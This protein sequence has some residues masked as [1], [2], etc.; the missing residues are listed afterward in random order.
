MDAIIIAFNDNSLERSYYLERET[1]R[2]FNLREDRIDSGTEEI[3]W[4]I[5][6]DDGRRFVQVPK[7][8]MEELMQEQ[9]SFV[10]S[11][12]VG[13][14]KNALSEVLESDSDGSGFDEFVN[15]HRQAREMWKAY[16]KVRSRER[17]D[18]WLRSLEESAR[19]VSGEQE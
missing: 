5:E 17:A 7:L 10:D 3:A 13:Q 2:I 19:D 14:L 11:V 15:R 9:E 12:Q 1:G 16:T 6:A 18:A 4:E 8:S